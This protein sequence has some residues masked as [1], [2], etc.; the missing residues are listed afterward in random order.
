MPIDIPPKRKPKQR[1]LAGTSALAPFDDP[2]PP[3]VSVIAVPATPTRPTVRFKT[4]PPTV[5]RMTNFP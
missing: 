3:Y 1:P 5:F 2:P 4:F